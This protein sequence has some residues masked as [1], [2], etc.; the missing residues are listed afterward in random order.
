MEGSDQSS[1]FRR[2]KISIKF[3]DLLDT[4]FSD[5]QGGKELLLADPNRRNDS[6]SGNANTVHRYHI[7]LERSLSNTVPILT[8]K[9]TPIIK[10]QI[11]D[12][13]QLP[14]FQT[15]SSLFPSPPKTAS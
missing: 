7:V 3:L 6:N 8:L 12:K 15:I 1:L 10:F 14:N 9:K 2:G 4:G 11:P 5:F 13:L